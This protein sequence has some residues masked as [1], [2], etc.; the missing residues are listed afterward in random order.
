MEVNHKEGRVDKIHEIENMSDY[1]VCRN[2]GITG[3]MCGQSTCTRCRFTKEIREWRDRN[4]AAILAS[5]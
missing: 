2:A 1:I 3:P 4:L 5:D